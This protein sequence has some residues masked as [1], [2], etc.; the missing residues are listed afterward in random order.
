MV[1][2]FYQNKEE[3]KDYNNDFDNFI[4]EIMQVFYNDL[5]KNFI[6]LIIDSRIN[7]I[8]RK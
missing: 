7:L 8:I 6:Y 4:K 3:S 1:Q 2:E 5:N